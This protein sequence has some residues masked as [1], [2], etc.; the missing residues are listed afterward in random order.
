MRTFENIGFSYSAVRF[1]GPSP[2]AQAPG[3][4]QAARFAD[5]QIVS[6]VERDSLRDWP[7]GNQPVI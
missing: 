6:S 5:G 1:G 7:D 2:S 4:F 3:D